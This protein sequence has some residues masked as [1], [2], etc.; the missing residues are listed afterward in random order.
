MAEKQFVVFKL[1]KEDYGIG[2]SNVKEIIPYKKSKK[3]PNTPDFIEGII[4]HRGEVTPI[5]CLKKRFGIK[6][7]IDDIS[8]RTIIININGRSTG[9]IVD[10]A[11]QTIKLE[12]NEIDS[13]PRI[14]FSSEKEYID[15]VGKKEDRLILLID[16]QKILTEK[17][18]LELEHIKT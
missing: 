18:K 8:M 15:G 17:E 5:I 1:E 16:L 3:I 14:L 10:E 4:N 11:S 2:I 13:P 9:F 12:E 6:R 7:E